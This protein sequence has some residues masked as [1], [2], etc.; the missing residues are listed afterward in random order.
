MAPRWNEDEVRYLQEHF[1]SAVAVTEIATA[2]GRSVRSI[3]NKASELSL[4]RPP[5][6]PTYDTLQLT[7]K[8]ENWPYT[9]AAGLGIV[10]KK[11]LPRIQRRL[12]TIVEHD[13]VYN[14]AYLWMCRAP[15]YNMSSL[16]GRLLRIFSDRAPG[17][18]E[19]YTPNQTR[20][21]LGAAYAPDA[22]TGEDI[23]HE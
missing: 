3:V 17:E 6:V 7:D 14:A 1:D 13:D 23:A 22:G 10:T 9:L 11:V 15:Y 4:N 18:G 19:V 12:G 16:E 8:P 5:P 20:L 21:D 2:L